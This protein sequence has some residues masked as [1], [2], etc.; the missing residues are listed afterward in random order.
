M[1][2]APTSKFCRGDPLWSPAPEHPMEPK[3]LEPE[4]LRIAS[5]PSELKASMLEIITTKKT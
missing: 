4:T 3:F 1:E 2:F 5:K